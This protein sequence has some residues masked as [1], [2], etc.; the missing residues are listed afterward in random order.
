[1]K[2]KL[3]TEK[4]ECGQITEE[5]LELFCDADFWKAYKQV[6]N[7]E[8]ESGTIEDLRKRVGL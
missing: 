8:L 3:T 1:M 4:K 5:Q 2:Y 6:K 7:N